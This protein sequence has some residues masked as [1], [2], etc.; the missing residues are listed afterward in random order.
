MQQIRIQKQRTA[1]QRDL[2]CDTDQPTRAISDT[3]AAGELLSRID[4]LLADGEA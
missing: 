3:T 1:C 4:A 2:T